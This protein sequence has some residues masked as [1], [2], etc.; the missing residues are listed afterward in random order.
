MALTTAGINYIAEAITGLGTPFDQ[1]N[2]YIGVGNGIVV[3][4][5]SQTDLQGD[6]KIRKALD[7]GYPIV[8]PPSVTFRATFAPAEANFDWQE[9]GIF[10]AGSG[11]VML[12]RVLES[13][14]TKQDNQTWVLEVAVTFALSN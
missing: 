10:N 2:A 3:F 14:G 8:N 1:T 6:S 9:W 11:G 4:D 13:N 5:E 7:G 12:S